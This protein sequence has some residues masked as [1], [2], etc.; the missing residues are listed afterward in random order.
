MAEEPSE[1]HRRADE[2]VRKKLPPGV[3][4]LHTLRGH[5]DWIGRIAWSP[6]GRKLASPSA[7]ETIRLWDPETGQCLR[8]LDGHQ[9][10]VISAA[11]DP[12]GR[13]LGERRRGRHDKA[14]GS[15]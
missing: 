3:E 14:L 12:D 7:D 10:G 11:F 8:T 5:R 6:D 9:G 2:E 4:L 15:E 1:Q 13:S